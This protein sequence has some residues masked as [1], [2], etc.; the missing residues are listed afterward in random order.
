MDEYNKIT[1]VKITLSR[2]RT[3]ITHNISTLSNNI[4][5]MP[6]KITNPKVKRMRYILKHLRHEI[7]ALNQSLRLFASYSQTNQ[8]L[9]GK[10]YHRR[11]YHG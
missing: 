1:T 4:G 10:S 3:A 11:Y 2:R 6:N 9:S 8:I 5:I 7:Q